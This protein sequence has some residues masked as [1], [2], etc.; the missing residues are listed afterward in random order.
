MHSFSSTSVN[1]VILFATGE[2]QNQQIMQNRKGM[3]S[4]LS[5]RAIFILELTLVNF[6]FHLNVGMQFEME[7]SMDIGDVYTVIK[8]MVLQIAPACLPK[9]WL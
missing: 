3:S 7:F 2:H 6:W 1:R 5:I 4:G 9:F 8:S